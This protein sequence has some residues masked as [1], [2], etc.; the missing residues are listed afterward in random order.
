MVVGVNSCLW[1][2]RDFSMQVALLLILEKSLLFSLPAKFLSKLKAFI[3]PVVL[4]RKIHEV[5]KM[6]QVWLD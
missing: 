4:S 6:P 3:G 1:E 2:G 5:T